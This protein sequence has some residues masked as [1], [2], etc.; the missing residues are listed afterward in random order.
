M[1]KKQK[2]ENLKKIAEILKNK[3]PDA[4][5]SLEFGGEAWRLLV[6]GRLSA[7]CTDERVNIVCRE[8]FQRFPTASDMAKADLSQIEEIVKPCGLYRTKAQNI[9]DSSK[10]LIENFGGVLPDTM[11]EL[12]T[13]PGVGRKIANL[14]LGDIFHRGGIVTDTHCIRIC[15]RF[16]MYPEKE[17]N[18]Y[19]IEMILTPL[20]PQEEASDFCHR[21]VLFG[22]EICTARSPKCEECEVGNL[23]LCKHR[24]EELKYTPLTPEKT[25]NHA[26]KN[27]T[28]TKKSEN[29][30][31]L[32]I[33]IPVIVEGKY[34]KITLSSI[35]DA[36]IIQTDGFAVFNKKEKLSLIRRLGEKYGVILLT[37]SDG[38]GKQIRSYLLS[39]L[40]KEKVINLYIPQIKG[41]E[42]RKKTAS[43]AGF[44]GV[45]GMDADRLRALFAPFAADAGNI[46]KDTAKK[47][48]VTKNDFYFDGL[49]GAD[50]SAEKRKLLAKAL[51]LPEDMTANALLEAVN[52]LIDKD[53][54]KRLLSSF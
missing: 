40:P 11:E 33:N 22:R 45:E 49:S 38:G 8:L 7:Q 25:E 34:D 41:K 31:K 32:R 3:Y 51:D 46:M 17:K 53:E 44:L 37:D 20:L 23:G 14:L 13:F 9:L 39:A 27:E 30:A 43:K 54:Y 5:C 2:S 48:T 4:A 24:N 35:L 52:L 10:M 1:T 36:H 6:M 18:P 47:E 19:K 26:Q 21:I 16:G 50:G 42:K 29:Q 15:G 12:L 28:A